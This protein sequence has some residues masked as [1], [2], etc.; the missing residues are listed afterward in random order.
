[1]QTSVSNLISCG[2]SRNGGCSDIGSTI[3]NSTWDIIAT[4]HHT[5]VGTTVLTGIVGP[6]SVKPLNLDRIKT[7]GFEVVATIWCGTRSAM[8]SVV[9][10]NKLTCNP[11]PGS[12]IGLRTD[13]HFAWVV[14]THITGETQEAIIH[15]S[16]AAYIGS[17]IIAQPFLDRSNVCAS[18][19][20]Q[21]SSGEHTHRASIVEDTL[22]NFSYTANTFGFSLPVTA[23]KTRTSIWSTCQ[24]Q[25][26]RPVQI[27]SVT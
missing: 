20:I 16:F 19:V 6:I 27:D 22:A 21:S 2:R 5:K 26:S 13:V 14:D 18:L 3:Q 24:R 12:I 11:D 7:R 1:M 23:I 10:N 9:I 25:N 8:A 4:G 17:T 15:V